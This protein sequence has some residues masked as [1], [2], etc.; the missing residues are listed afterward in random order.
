MI[1]QDLPDV[2]S[3]QR[4]LR[5]DPSDVR[6]LLAL[7][8]N[9]T[10]SKEYTKAVDVYFQL[11]KADSN[12]FHAY[13]N[14]GIIYKKVGQFNDSLRCFAKASQL[15]S[16]SPVLHYNIGLTYEA[17]GRMQEARESYGRA[18][19]LNPDLSQ[20]LERL[21]NLSEDPSKAP[22]LPKPPDKLLIA[23]SSEGKPREVSVAASPKAAEKV[24]ESGKEQKPDAAAKAE[25]SSTTESDKTKEPDKAK[26]S[27]KADKPKKPEKSEKSDLSYRTIRQGA[28]ALLYNKAMASFQNNDMPAAI[29]SYCLALLKDRE[30]L[31]EPDFGLIQSGISLLRD[32]PNSHTESLFFLGFL[33]SVTGD[34][35]KAIS[36]L[37]KYVANSKR[38][39]FLADARTVIDRYEA[40]KAEQERKNQEEAEVASRQTDLEK[41]G[42]DTRPLPVGS[43]TP[44]PSDVQLKE[45]NV[46]EILEEANKM[47][48][49]GRLR[50]SL[51]ILK[52][53]F[54]REP[55]NIPLLSAIGNVYTD[56]MLLQGDP[57]A[58][59]MAREIF[60]KIINLTP[61]DSKESKIAQSMV[62]ELS[63]RIR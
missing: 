42:L 18:L 11:L 38:G 24:E 41:A 33:E 8:M 51:A 62:K 17:M 1:S 28:G 12:N 26:E 5:D 9:Y 36:D 39:A 13:H 43:F 20:A 58:G 27:D 48:R 46:Q 45:L 3:L 50:D 56:M 34:M 14:L 4:R 23:D 35:E 2:E 22:K 10:A 55:E 54:E 29:E 32:R 47:S 60:E 15:N 7:A 16:D 40:L 6:S 57:E 63:D 61:P 37:N 59:K 30:I 53:G 21:R 31:S 49:E 52:N 25:K 19:S 44:R